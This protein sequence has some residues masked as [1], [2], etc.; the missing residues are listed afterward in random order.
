M[1]N[2]ENFIND[3]SENIYNL[4]YDVD[5]ANRIKCTFISIFSLIVPDVKEILNA[6]NLLSR[7]DC[8]HASFWDSLELIMKPQ[9]RKLYSK[10]LSLC[11]KTNKK[12]NNENSI[13]KLFFNSKLMRKD[14]SVNFI[15]NNRLKV[16]AP[17]TNVSEIKIQCSENNNI[18]LFNYNEMIEFMEGNIGM[19]N[20]DAGSFISDLSDSDS[21]E[22]GKNCKYNDFFSKVNYETNH[23]IDDLEHSLPKY[24]DSGIDNHS[25]QV[26]LEQF[27][28]SSKI[29]HYISELSENVNKLNKSNKLS[30]SKLNNEQEK[31]NYVIDKLE[32]DIIKQKEWYNLGESS[33]L[34][35]SKNSLLDLH[36]EIPRFSNS[37]NY[38]TDK[39][40]TLQDINKE[41]P[42][43]NKSDINKYIEGIV[44]QRIVDEIF[45][46]VS[47]IEP[48]TVETMQD[49]PEI[50][51]EK[52]KLSLSEIYSKKYEEQVIG[53]KFNDDIIKERRALAEQFSLIMNKL[54][55]LSN[56]YFTSG[57]P[58]VLNIER[59]D[60]PTLKVEDT[61]PVIVSDNT[62]IAPQELKKQGK[63]VSD[64][65]LT[66]LEKKASRERNKRKLRN[67]NNGKKEKK[68][69]YGKSATLPENQRNIKSLNKNSIDLPN[70]R[71]KSHHFNLG[72]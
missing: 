14:I 50:Q 70:K 1:D 8:N 64:S 66:H 34:N 65:E 21:E 5:E 54:D 67:K 16:T 49:T 6:D 47:K 55:S 22:Y 68:E 37:D 24:I 35:R 60:I 11:N 62:R 58:A 36:L 19:S 29:P 38:E 28:S 53:N 69:T 7:C 48:I 15:N 56:Q 13:S 12:I 41:H 20:E 31:V 43:E 27:S 52:S 33:T 18:D 2:I 32:E 10:I 46:E 61:I 63:F 51:V 40:D 23:Y 71:I 44:K 26:P 25:D 57:I 4:N 59:P 30:K 45:D 3:L 42:T 39:Y 9:I 17:D 72:N